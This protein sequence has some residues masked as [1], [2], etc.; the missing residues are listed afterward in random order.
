MAPAWQPNPDV[1]MQVPASTGQ[2]PLTN[3]TT[4]QIQ[5]VAEATMPTID[6]AGASRLFIGIW[7]GVGIQENP[8]GE[9]PVAIS[10][11]GG[12]L[13]EIVG[14]S[15]YLEQSCGG[16]LILQDFSDTE[17]VLLEQLTYGQAAC[18]DNGTIVLSGYDGATI[19]FTWNGIGPNG[20]P[21]SA[22]GRLGRPDNAAPPDDSPPT[23]EAPSS[24]GTALPDTF[25]GTTWTGTGQQE[26][27]TNSWP[28]TVSLTGGNEGDVIGTIDY[29]TLGC[30]GEI[31]LTEVNVEDNFGSFW[32]QEHITYGQENCIDG[33]R[34][35]FFLS[36]GAFLLN[37]DWTSPSGPTTATGQLEPN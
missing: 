36:E 28:V 8:H 15:V 34:F 10:I 29:P 14:T 16:N 24:S 17:I 21:S 3:V 20:T 19:Q 6:A 31:V 5:P 23:S 25:A 4:E 35:L 2:A 12:G 22:S 32:A 33:G 30:G 1:E 27:P 18:A 9:W 26:N 11:T 37:F 13:G 7:D